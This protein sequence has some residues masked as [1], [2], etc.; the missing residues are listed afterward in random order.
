MSTTTPL[1]TVERL[2]ARVD[3]LVAGTKWMFGLLLIVLSVPN[4]L[5]SLS[6]HRVQEIFQNTLPGKPLPELTLAV[7]MHPGLC[8]LLAVAWP[9]AAFITIVPS[10]R[11]RIWTRAGALIG[12]AIGLQFATTLFVLLPMVGLIIEGLVF[13]Q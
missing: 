9:V 2:T 5:T 13:P 11:V 12:L 7:V 1:P 3:D 6:I 4:L 10:E 8:Q